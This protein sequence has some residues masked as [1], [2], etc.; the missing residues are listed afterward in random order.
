MFKGGWGDAISYPLTLQPCL[1]PTQ[2][3]KGIPFNHLSV[4]QWLDIVNLLYISYSILM[5]D[6]I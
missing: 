3:T 4:M 1:S 5:L 2:A 6:V